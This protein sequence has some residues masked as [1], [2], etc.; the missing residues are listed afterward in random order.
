M[1]VMIINVTDIRKYER[2]EKR[3]VSF[4]WPLSG[5]RPTHLSKYSTAVQERKSWQKLILYTPP[6]EPYT[7]FPVAA[8]F[9]SSVEAAESSCD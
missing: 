6:S 3:T 7:V 8:P 1:K 2:K 4:A 9:P 5:C